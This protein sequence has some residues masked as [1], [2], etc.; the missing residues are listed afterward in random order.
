MSIKS[1]LFV[2]HALKRIESLL[3]DGVGYY[4][5]I[6]CAG[7]DIA[8]NLSQEIEILEEKEFS[9]MGWTVSRIKFMAK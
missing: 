9:Y 8:E 5:Y 7:Q 4:Y 3:A 6:P 1:R 2:E